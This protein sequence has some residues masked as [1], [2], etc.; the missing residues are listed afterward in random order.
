MSLS[1]P[2]ASTHIKVFN[3]TSPPVFAHELSH[4]ESTHAN[5]LH[6]PQHRKDCSSGKPEQSVRKNLV[7][8]RWA[9]ESLLTIYRLP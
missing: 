4:V 1:K 6:G 3:I 8:I 7:S 9:A 2:R 5:N